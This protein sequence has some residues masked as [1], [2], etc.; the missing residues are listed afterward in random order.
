[1]LASV[2]SAPLRTIAVDVLTNSDDNAAE[3]LLKELGTTRRAARHP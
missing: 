2:Q 3:M 1:M